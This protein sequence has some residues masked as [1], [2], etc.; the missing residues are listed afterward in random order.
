MTGY[1]AGMSCKAMQCF[2]AQNDATHYTT[3]RNHGSLVHRPTPHQST[4]YH[5][6]VEERALRN[7]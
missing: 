7:T 3:L 4:A 5:R 2:A 6:N 1:D